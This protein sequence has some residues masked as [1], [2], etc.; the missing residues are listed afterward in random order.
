MFEAVV[1]MGGFGTRLKS[2]SGDTPKP[3]VE[4]AG[5]PFVYHLLERLEKAGCT[6]II[7]SLHYRAEHIKRKI[8]KDLP[9]ACELVFAIEDSP[10]GTGGAIKLAAEYIVG[11]R[12]IAINGD[13]HCEIDY[14]NYFK[15]SNTSDV[16]ISAIKVQN[17]ERY[18]ALNYNYDGYLTSITEKGISRPGYINSGNYIIN[19]SVIKNERKSVF[20][21]E[22]YFLPKH[23][24]RVKVYKFSGEFIDIGIPED[25]FKARDLLR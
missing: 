21:F 3:M 12:F 5:R 17:T 16:I 1:L 25:Y 19:T 6:K 15:F 11:E 10:R 14:L 23:I 13:T 24:G 4:V 7:L 22:E 18:G 9:V 20:S 8:I 2:V